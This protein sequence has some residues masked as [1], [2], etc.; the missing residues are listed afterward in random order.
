MFKYQYSMFQFLTPCYKSIL[1]TICHLQSKFD[2]NFID[3]WFASDWNKSCT[4]F[5]K[6]IAVTIAL[7]VLEKLLAR[8]IPE[9]VDHCVF[10]HLTS[11]LT[12]ADHRMRPDFFSKFCSQWQW[13]Q[14]QFPYNGYFN[15]KTCYNQIKIIIYNTEYTILK[16][17]CRC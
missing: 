10:L 3:L 6:K 8:W 17:K 11:R 12:T 5:E 16:M 9:N 7:E 4:T 1:F 13:K 2:G 14:W 15:A